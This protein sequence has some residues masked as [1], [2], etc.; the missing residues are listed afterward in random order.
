LFIFMVDSD[1][2][3]HRITILYVIFMHFNHVF[4]LGRLSSSSKDHR[5]EVS[6]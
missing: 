4:V 6:K 5:Y 3:E 1:D 2:K